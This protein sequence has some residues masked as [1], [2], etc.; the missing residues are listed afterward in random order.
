MNKKNKY[1]ILFIP[2]LSLISCGDPSPVEFTDNTITTENI[3]VGIVPAKPSTYVYSNGYDSTGI[4]E[5]FIN[6]NTIVN[7]S[8]I[9]NSNYGSFADGT[10]YFALFNDKTKPVLGPGNSVVGYKSKSVISVFFNN[11]QAQQESNSMKMMNQ[12]HTQVDTSLGLKYVLSNGMAHGMHGGLNNPFP[13]GSS[14][15]VRIND[16]SNPT[17]QFD[18]PTPNEIIG[19]IKLQGAVSTNNLS[20]EL[21]WNGNANDSLN[22][23]IGTVNQSSN[24]ANPLFLFKIANTNSL[25]VP[26]SILEKIQFNQTKYLVVTLIKRIIKGISY[27][28]VLKDSYIASQSIHNI[29]VDIP[30]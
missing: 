5:P 4:I 9:H 26:W 20:I 14:I 7:V 15:N 2:L 25:K 18:L 16:G 21:T 23:I 12:Q 3:N 13:Y 19:Q 28:A 29:K 27:N 10:Y 22:V 8:G 6:K 11:V 1:L 17:Y 24:D 30:R